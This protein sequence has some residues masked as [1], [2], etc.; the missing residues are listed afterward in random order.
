MPQGQVF[1]LTEMDEES[2]GSFTETGLAVASAVAEIMVST[3]A[4]I[5]KFDIRKFDLEF[6]RRYLLFN[7]HHTDDSQC[8]DSHH[9]ESTLQRRNP[10]VAHLHSDDVFPML[11]AI[12]RV[13]QFE[14]ATTGSG[15]VT[16]R[17]R[18]GGP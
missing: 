13:G 7:L 16:R 5:R 3:W 2:A 10:I 6:E 4:P 11:V 12:S 18:T 14:A 15:V 8:V 17:Q 1:P 9:R